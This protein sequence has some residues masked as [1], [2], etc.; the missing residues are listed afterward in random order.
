MTTLRE[1]FIRELTIRGRAERTIHAYVASLASLAKH[2][3]RPPDRIADEEV[4]A[5]AD[6]V[7]GRREAL[8]VAGGR[9]GRPRPVW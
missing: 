5:C 8:L 4:R 6:R 7:G 2:Y 1:K 3:G 9:A